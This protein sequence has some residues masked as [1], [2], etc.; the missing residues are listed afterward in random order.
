MDP[1]LLRYYNRE[2]QFVREMG[3]EY[4]KAFPKVAGRLGIEGLECADPYV[5]R[6]LEGFAF[7]AARVQLKLDAQFPRFT[8]HLLECVYPDYLCPI[9]S[10]AVVQLQPDPD[11]GALAEGFPIPRDTVLRSLLGKDDQTACEYRTGHPVTLWPLAVEEVEYLPTAGTVAALG[12]DG[13]AGL[14]AGLR[15]RLRTTAGLDFAKIAIESLP[16]HLR[17]A[18]EIGARLH[19][20][21]VANTIAVAACAVGADRKRCTRV[22]GARVRALGFDDHHALLPPA[23]RSFSGYRLL[24][25]YFAFAERYLFVEFTDIG[26]SL[27]RIGGKQ[28]DLVIAFDRVAPLLENALDASSVAL[29]CTPVINLFPKRAD[30]IHLDGPGTEHHVVPDRTRPLDFEVYTVTEVDGYGG[31]E[32]GEQRFLP[33]YA[34]HDASPGDDRGTYFTVNRRP[35]QLS[36]RQRREGARSSYVGHELFVSLVDANE[37]PLRPDL[38]QLGLGTLCTNRD[39]PLYISLGKQNTDFTLESGAPVLA[40]RCLS[41]PTRPRPTFAEGDL[42]WRI[43]SH[44][45]LNYLSIVDSDERHGAAALREIMALY[46]DASEPLIG[47][48]IEGVRSIASKAI[49]R[50]LPTPGLITM[51]RGIEIEL[52]LEESAFEGTGVFLLGSV[53]DQFF[54]RYASIN[55]FTETVLKTTERGEIMRW[56]TRSGQRHT[57]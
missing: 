20:Q 16:I 34:S 36:T 15:V 24:R 11:E 14:R 56:P 48:Q 7:L 2:L 18:G 4:A 42:A 43:I 53:L 26:D 41:G 46:G 5:E 25:E 13:V 30:R 40:V 12:L 38:H 35:R 8:Q 31:A 21:I 54:A 29:F 55:S 52:G 3:A 45:S 6:L 27:R 37:A 39:L 28:V 50:R 22:A 1:R 17:G 49:V 44:L 57:I 19:E 32:Q 10:M 23:P 51:G 47:K 9:P 33:L